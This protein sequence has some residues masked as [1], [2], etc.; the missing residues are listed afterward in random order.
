VCFAFIDITI[1]V[2]SSETFG[3]LTLIAIDGLFNTRG[4]VLAWCADTLV[5]I[6]VTVATQV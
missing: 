3:T 4:A 6:Y 1:A 5:D 2:Q